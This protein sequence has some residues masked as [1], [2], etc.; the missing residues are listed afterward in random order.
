MDE[1][2]AWKIISRIMWSSYVIFMAYRL[3]DS[4]LLCFLGFNFFH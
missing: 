1:E 4:F 2:R 3:E